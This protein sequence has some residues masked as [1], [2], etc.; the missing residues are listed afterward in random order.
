MADRR[1][2][3]IGQPAAR[4]RRPANQKLEAYILHR[5][6]EEGGIVSP[7]SIARAGEYGL[8]EAKEALDRLVESGYAEFRMVKKTGVTVYVIAE[9][10]DGRRGEELEEA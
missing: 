4:M 3:A 8:E 1:D 10:L 2:E 5:A 6:A 9:L 7:I